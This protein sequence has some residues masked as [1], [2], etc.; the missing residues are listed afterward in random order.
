MSLSLTNGA[1][2]WRYRASDED[3]H[4]TVWKEHG[5]FGNTDFTV[6]DTVF[7]LITILSPSS[8]DFYTYTVEVDSQLQIVLQGNATDSNGLASVS[9]S[10]DRGQT[11]GGL[12]KKDAPYLTYD[13]RTDPIPLHGGTTTIYVYVRDPQ[14]NPGQDVIY[15]T[16]SELQFCIRR[17]TSRGWVG[18]GD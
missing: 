15:V 5:I 16:V 18:H 1:Y 12:L 3:G 7:P 11:G 14:G 2:H 6:T 13:W 8:S 4:S 17:G 10:N 9:W